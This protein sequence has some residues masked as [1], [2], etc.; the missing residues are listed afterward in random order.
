MGYGRRRGS[1]CLS[2]FAPSSGQRASPL[3]FRP[4]VAGRL[5]EEKMLCQRPPQQIIFNIKSSCSSAYTWIFP[6]VARP[7]PASRDQL[8]LYYPSSVGC[9]HNGAAPSSSS[10]HVSKSDSENSQ[11]PSQSSDKARLFL[12]S[13]MLTSSSNLVTWSSSRTRN[14]RESSSS[15]EQNRSHCCAVQK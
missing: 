8:S 5:S 10:A 12:T 9:S 15:P 13:P 11:C 1:G 6:L 3:V 4:C 14:V 2:L 7:D